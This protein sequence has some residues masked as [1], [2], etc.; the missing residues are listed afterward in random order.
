MAASL[1]STAPSR[2]ER[3]FTFAWTHKALCISLAGLA[4]LALAALFAPL[5]VGDDPLRLY[6]LERLQPPSAAH[7]LGTDQY[8]RDVFARLVYGAR[9][10]LSVGLSTAFLCS[11]IGLLLGLLSGFMRSLDAVLMRVMDGLMAIPG[12]LLA[13]TLVA[14]TSASMTSVIIA[15]VV[16]ETPRVV[17][18]VRGIVLTIR[19]RQHV[20]A[21]ITIGTRIPALLSRHVMPFVLPPLMVQAVGVCSA[22]ILI[23]AS[24]S[25]VGAGAPPTTP[26]WGV[27]IADGRMYF[28]L[29]PWLVLA[30][31]LMLTLSILAINVAGDR[32]RALADPHGRKRL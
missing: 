7:W 27:M 5:L 21:A 26:S 32:L 11:V 1:A 3:V 8:G 20:E 17:R 22:A 29:A 12:I 14:L 6:P 18:L 2:T 25:F 10:S 4:L 28:Q 24:L 19:E 13:I 15:I 30:P 9:M 23:E 31:G 16:P